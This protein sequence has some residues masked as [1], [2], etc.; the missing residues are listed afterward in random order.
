MI[1]KLVMKGTTYKVKFDDL[2]DRGDLGMCD[3]KNKIIWLD[4]NLSEADRLK[5]LLHEFFHAVDSC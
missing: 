2:S 1:S 4:E 5:T 3:P